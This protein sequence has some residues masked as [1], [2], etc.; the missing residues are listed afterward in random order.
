MENHTED[1]KP[2]PSIFRRLPLLPILFLYNLGFFIVR[3]G[4]FDS[5][6][7]IGIGMLIFGWLCIV[8]SL[9]LSVSLVISI[10][11]T[12]LNKSN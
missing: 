7:A 4:N 11:K 12:A 9:A 6:T 10:F 1:T 8:G 2:R 3:K 5:S